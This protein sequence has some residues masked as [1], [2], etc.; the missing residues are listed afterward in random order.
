MYTCD[1]THSHLWQ[2]LLTGVARLVDKSSVDKIPSVTR[3]FH[4][5]EMTDS[6]LW[7]DSSH[8]WHDWFTS[9]KWIGHMYNK[10]HLHVLH[11]CAFITRM[12]IYS[13]HLHPT[14]CTCIWQETHLHSSRSSSFITRV[15]IYQ[16]HFHSS[17]AFASVTLI[18]ISHTHSHLSHSFASDKPHVHQWHDSFAEE[19]WLV[20]WGDMTRLLRRHDS[21][22]GWG[23]M[24]RLLRW[25]DSFV[26]ETW[27]V[28]W[29][30]M[31]LS[32]VKRTRTLYN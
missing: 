26:E 17:H 32:E 10:S 13:T 19:T 1:M 30:H 25:H 6:H 8:V 29:G 14:R 5:C 2:N 11:P 15:C 28:C 31:T 3:L 20:C 27:L 23:D 16:T 4:T 24:T 12:C 21:F 22:A 18:H 9:V 7:R